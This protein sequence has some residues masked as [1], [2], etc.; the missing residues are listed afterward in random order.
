MPRYKRGKLL[1]AG[2]LLRKLAK[3]NVGRTFWVIARRSN[4]SPFKGTVADW[5]IAQQLYANWSLFY[6]AAYEAYNRPPDEIIMDD[7]KIDEWFKFQA[8][9]REFD[10]QENYRTVGFQGREGHKSAYS[11]DEVFEY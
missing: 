5:T 7:E 10:H 4:V 9:Q 2:E 3:S 11:H 6:D 8:E 1:T